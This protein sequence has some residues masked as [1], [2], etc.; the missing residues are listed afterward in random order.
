MNSTMVRSSFYLEQGIFTDPG[1]FSDKFKSLPDGVDNLIKVVQ[2]LMVHPMEADIY[3]LNFTSSQIKEEEQLRSA[4]QIIEKITQIDPRDLNQKRDIKDKIIGICRDHAI[5]LTSMLR[6]KGIPARIR[7]GF[8]SYF[9]SEIDIQTHWVVDYWNKDKGCWVF[10]DPQID[11]LQIK[12]HNI[13]IDP[14]NIKESE[15]YSAGRAWLLV[16]SGEKRADDFGLN[17]KWRGLPVL[18]SSLIHDFLCL[19]SIE[20]LAWDIWGELASKSYSKLNK[21]ERD[22]LDHL[23]LLTASRESDEK[24]ITELYSSLDLKREVDNKL[25]ILSLNT[26]QI[27]IATKLKTSIFDSFNPDIYESQDH[28]SI[29]NK[30]SI[31]LD[32]GSDFNN[33][34][35]EIVI[36]GARQNNLKNIDVSIKKNRLTVVTGV[37]G[38]G[39]SSLAFDTVYAEGRR[40]YMASLSAYARRFVDSLEK[41]E[42][43]HIIGVHPA[44]AIEQKTV[45]RNPRSTVGSISEIYD[46][47]RV[48]FSGIG[49][50]HCPC[51]GSSIEA[52]SSSLLA[53]K[54]LNQNRYN[55]IMLKALDK[56]VKVY[57]DKMSTESLTEEIDTLYKESCVIEAVLDSEFSLKFTRERKCIDCGIEIDELKPALFNQNS[58]DG[59]CPE[60]SGLGKKLEVDPGLIVTDENLSLLDGASPW[61]GELRKKRRSAN[62]MVGEMYALADYHGVDLNK[63]WKEYPE[64]F[65]KEVL[66]GSNGKI[67]RYE[68]SN[69]KSSSLSVIERAAVGAVYNITR[70]YRGANCE[71]SRNRLNQYF[72]EISCPV[73]R[74]EKIG[75]VARLVTVGGVRFPEVANMTVEGVQNWLRSIE[76]LCNYNR[77]IWDII[78]D[79]ENRLKFLLDVGLHYL[80]LS[81]PAP[82]LS[83]GEGQRIRLATQ[84]GSGLSGILYVLDEP[85]VG[86]HPR[87]H[88]PLIKSMKD[89]T[90]GGN[91]VLVVEHNR[92]TMLEADYIID[93]GPGAG[94]NGGEVVSQGSPEDIIKCEKSLTGRYLNNNILVRSDKKRAIGKKTIDLISAKLNNLKDVDLSIPLGNFIGIS[95]VSGSGKSS[96]ISKTLVPALENAIKGRAYLNES[97]KELRGWEHI[98][99]VINVTQEPIGRTP[100]SNPVTYVE[101]FDHIRSIFVKQDR[102]KELG[103]DK[104]Y[105]SFNSKK[106]CCSECGGLGKKKIEMNFLPDGFSQ[107]PECKGKRFNRSVLQVLWKGF[108]IADILDMDIDR[109][110]KLFSEFPVIES[111]LKTL[112]DV[113]LGYIKL[114]QS[115]L[116]FSGGEAQRIKLAKEL[117]KKGDGRSLYILDEPTTGLH[118]SDVEKLLILLQKLVDAGNSVIVIEHNMDVLSSV[119]WI[120]DL[121]PDGGDKG[122]YI[123]AQG[124]PEEII[125][126]KSSVTGRYLHR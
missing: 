108:S 90:Y 72:K 27:D 81:R 66:Y 38:S 99:R 55:F 56:S 3:G 51:C 10:I 22:I 73:C 58:V 68:Y 86:L 29:E 115:A 120:V 8:A 92:E 84:L 19:N 26:E 80:A 83:G 117:C 116:T 12:K 85:S 71:E 25:R 75:P 65:K 94:V 113:G 60:C 6:Y 109:A 41:P 52:V 44:I 98:G 69:G 89:L 63:S 28:S 123:L 77:A 76:R 23:A 106:G 91:T 104:S 118:F 14:L 102:S 16:N 13:Q 64:D 50:P 20:P 114:G 100:R 88:E 97:F 37:S 1:R 53:E 18:K 101:I 107:C 45:S 61:F 40:R 93:I 15:F 96:L 2:N 47:L 67:V 121:G 17:K 7:V 39:K 124:R 125:N 95:G 62:W 24:R 70:L 105:F 30:T 87:D 34:R 4:E 110:Y 46:Y 5:L 49:L 11:S 54:L 59:S 42:I 78:K 103:L 112:I 82:T 31:N 9:D 57:L 79:I 48:L 36:R 74:E 43:D 126:N 32:L 111:M 35:N 122:G 21:S 33:N 119:D